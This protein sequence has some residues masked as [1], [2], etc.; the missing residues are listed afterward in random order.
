MKYIILDM[1]GNETPILFESFVS[2]DFFR[3]FGHLIVSAG[4]VKLY[5]TD[6]CDPNSACGENL[7]SVDA[8]GESTSL[9]VK[10]RPE[11][12]EIISKAIHHHYNHV[13]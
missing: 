10:S 7:M 3:D 5:G 12:A 4:T 13:D 8:F 9:K 6:A 2:H 11:D 1:G